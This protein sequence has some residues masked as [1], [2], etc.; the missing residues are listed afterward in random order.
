MMQAMT[1]YL[2][3]D[4]SF[5]GSR[6]P[7]SDTL[8]GAICWGYELLFGEPR[9]ISLLNAFQSESAPFLISSMFPYTEKDGQ[10][11]LSLPKPYTKPYQLPDNESLD[12]AKLKALKNLKKL[13]TVDLDEFSA[14]LNGEK[15]EAMFY[16]EILTG[17]RHRRTQGQYFDVPHAAINRLTGSVEGPRFFYTE[18]YTP[19]S[20]AQKQAGLFFLVKCREDL[21]ADLQTVFRFL[22][23]K[24]LGGGVSVGKGHFQ[25][26]KIADELPYREPPE[27]THVV[28]LSLTF[29]CEV[30]R[31]RLSESWYDIERR[32]GKIE[33]MYAHVEH[34]WKDHLI[35]LKEG[36]TFPKNGQ[37]FYGE[38]RIVRRDDGKLGFDV[39]HYGYAFTVNTRHIQ[40]TKN[41][42]EHA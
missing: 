7:R 3:P 38:N 28:T 42:K 1:V 21:A 10:R 26:V 30:I 14:M 22:G 12:L 35:M 2:R 36:S 8:F 18:E 32:Q 16:Q 19:A 40:T 34:I 41:A 27:A 39:R 23:D 31:S 15:T 37:P 20:E 33:S 11:S 6:P 9:L 29:P 17:T 25:I 5:R 24:G 4:S 13:G